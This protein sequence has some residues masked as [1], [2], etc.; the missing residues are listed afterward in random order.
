MIFEG[1]HNHP[2]LPQHKLTYPARKAVRDAFEVVGDGGVTA[3]RLLN[4]M[5]IWSAA[6][7]SK[8]GHV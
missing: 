2:P 8:L 1:Q 7:P 5:S 4:G 3:G 6:L